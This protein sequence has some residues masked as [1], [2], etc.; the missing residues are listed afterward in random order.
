MKKLRV[1]IVEQELKFRAW[2]KDTKKMYSVFSF[3]DK[4][5]KFRIQK[6]FRKVE[7]LREGLIVKRPRN[8]FE[9]LM[10]YIGAKYSNGISKGSD[11]F[12]GDIVKYGNRIAEIIFYNGYETCGFAMYSKSDNYIFAI[13]KLIIKKFKKIGDVYNNKDLNK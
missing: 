3:C 6:P 2:N 4:Y 1:K 7:D 12:V 10:Q 8:E 9:P 5:V 11:I 13:N